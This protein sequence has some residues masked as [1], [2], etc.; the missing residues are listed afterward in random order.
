MIKTYENEQQHIE[1]LYET[2]K[3][4]SKYIRFDR[5]P[6]PELVSFYKKNYGINTDCHH[7]CHTCQITQINKY[8]KQLENEYEQATKE[9]KEFKWFKI[10]CSYIMDGLSSIFK[11]KFD[12]LV[13][14]GMDRNKAKRL[15]LMA[16]DPVAW[17]EVMFGFD[18]GSMNE[19]EMDRRWY[20]RWY[21]KHTLR[22]TSRRMVLRQGRRS[23]KSSVIALKLINQVFNKKVFHA[24]DSEGNEIYKG[25]Q[26]VIVTPFKS[27]LQVIYE[28]LSKF[29]YLNDDLKN[30]VLVTGD[31]LYRQTPPLLMTFKNGATITGLISGATNKEDGTAGGNMR[32]ISADI[33]YTDEMDMIPDA[34]FK[35]VL[36]PIIT[37]TKPNTVFYG[38]STPIGKKSNFYSYCLESPNFKEIYV[39]STVLPHWTEKEEEEI[40]KDSTKD[41][42]RAEYLADFIVDSYGVFKGPYIHAA[43]ENYTYEE[44][45]D[46]KFWK[47]EYGTNFYEFSIS[48]G[49]DWNKTVGTEYSVIA[50]DPFKGRFW[51]LENFTIAPSEYSGETYKDELKRLNYKWRPNYIAPDEG[52]G[53][54]LIE[55]L[56]VEA[57][58]LMGKKDKTKFEQATVRLAS[59][60][61]PIN[62]SSNIELFNPGTG[63]KFTK[64]GKDFL[65]ENAVQIFE[66]GKISFAE[67]DRVLVNQLRNYIITDKKDNGKLIY[68]MEVESIGDH[69]LDAFMLALGSLIMNESIF[70]YQTG[71]DSNT[72]SREVREEKVAIDKA[73]DI[74]TIMKQNAESGSSGLDRFKRSQMG[75]PTRAEQ[76]EKGLF[77]SFGI[78]FQENKSYLERGDSKPVKINPTTRQNVRKGW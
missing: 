63:Q 2:N 55:S 48:M 39:P 46:P 34:V 24:R 23:G 67:T 45:S 51:T 72:Y 62:F 74:K 56:V 50:W 36:K 66:R 57:T 41:G 73:T 40:L 27:Q 29:I 8:K 16:V 77:G 12:Q 64:Y 49:I 4:G 44:T 59:I 10:P 69:R 76:K 19:P 9:K 3:F 52:Y 42:F 47:E 38:S 70:S 43:R 54:F 53:N 18:D 26:I 14:G 60:M 58:Q 71:F 31:K 1:A 25:P 13:K 21:Q 35:D 68:G 75:V 6:A 28:E 65:V 5:T 30:E 32:G 15:L 37:I 17:T 33:I 22:C 11:V 20:V 7:S 78:D 61:K